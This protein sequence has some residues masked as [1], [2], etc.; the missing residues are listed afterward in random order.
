MGFRFSPESAWSTFGLGGRR[1][2]WIRDVSI[3]GRSAEPPSAQS[4]RVLS[5]EGRLAGEQAPG[6]LGAGEQD[7]FQLIL[8]AAPHRREAAAAVAG[9]AQQL[10]S[11]VRFW[12]DLPPLP[13]G[14]QLAE[15][16]MARRFEFAEPAP[17][18][19]DLAEE[20]F[21]FEESLRA[22]ILRQRRRPTVWPA[23]LLGLSVAL[24]AAAVLGM[25][26]MA[27]WAGL[28]LGAVSGAATSAAVLAAGL[29]A[30]RR[31]GDG[32]LRRRFQA[33]WATREERAT[34]A[35]RYAWATWDLHRAEARV[36]WRG[37]EAERIARVR[38]LCGGDVE[39]VR[40]C[41]EATLADLDF[42]YPTACEFA[43]DGETAFVL[44]DLPE[45]DS[46]VP[47]VRVEV[48]QEL[49]VTTVEVGPAE[50]HEAYRE[51]VAGIALLIA[52]AA[53]AAAPKLRKVQLA[54]YRQGPNADAAPV[55]YVVDVLI[56]RE[57]AGKLDP[58]EVDPAAFLA[59]LPG[60]FPRS[61]S[62]LLAGLPAPPWLSEAFGAYAL[63]APG[64]AWK[65]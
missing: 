59:G 29:R 11:M 23:L 25:S 1:Y 36:A 6:A 44:L 51:H 9:A 8:D 14:A 33:E 20:R 26:W 47:P 2:S 32:A 38:R 52:R 54:G 30:W 37:A 35:W 3:L 28:G 63:A 65:N 56:D 21:A 61:P 4:S 18:P 46:V 55:E 58:A 60:A 27:P 10:D 17:S 48:D 41:L 43:T 42:P 31:W 45:V 49:D 57:S 5:R 19:P 62:G 12:R 34:A 13:T 15:A 50:R 39:A 40:G 16:A 22:E 7:L 53:F 64:L 24:L